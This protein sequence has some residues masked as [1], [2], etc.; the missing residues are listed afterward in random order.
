MVF[1]QGPSAHLG[2]LATGLGL[3]TIFSNSGIVRF[4]QGGVVKTF[5]WTPQMALWQFDVQLMPDV[6]VPDAKSYIAA[7]FTEDG[8]DTDHWW[9]HN[10]PSPDFRDVIARYFSP[11]K[12]WS[13]DLLHWGAEKGVLIECW[14]DDDVFSLSA[15]L[16]LPHITSDSIA[17]FCDCVSE[18]DCHLYVMETQ[19]VVAPQP[20]LL[21]QHI[22]DSRAAKFCS[23][24]RGFLE[25]LGDSPSA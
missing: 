25:D 20:V 7:S 21:H 1:T 8:L 23:N 15:R 12:S 9:R 13:D 22:L 24:P 18:L 2:S 16:A 11:S 17:R 4:V 19:V 3:G 14:D 5:R 10:Q 6:I